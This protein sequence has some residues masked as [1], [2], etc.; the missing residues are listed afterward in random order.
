MT[1]QE[2][3]QEC[4]LD[5]VLRARGILAQYIEP[6]PHD[7]GQTLARLFVI[8]DDEELTNAVN[9]LN[10]EA[11]GAAMAAAKR[12]TTSPPYSRTSD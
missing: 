11:A 5:A 12:S 3:P 7:C 6:G 1:L 8:F 2:S 9:V 10:L 4:V